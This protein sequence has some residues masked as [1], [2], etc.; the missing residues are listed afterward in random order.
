MFHSKNL[1]GTASGMQCMSHTIVYYYYYISPGCVCDS[2]CAIDVWEH[3]TFNYY[4]MLS[5]VTFVGLLYRFVIISTS[6]SK[7]KREM[8][9]R[10][11]IQS[12]HLLFNEKKN[13]TKFRI[14]NEQNVQNSYLFSA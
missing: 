1:V 13:E 3:G 4:I 2:Q 11:Q 10:L 5:I 6:P 14:F 8:R 9:N 7:A 12:L